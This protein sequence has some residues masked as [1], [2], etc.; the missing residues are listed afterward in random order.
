MSAPSTPVRMEEM[1]WPQVQ[2]ALENGY[3]TVLLAAASIEQHGPHLPT[4]T[5]TLLGY[6]LAEEVALRLGNALVAPVLRPGCSRHHMGFPGSLTL[7]FE[8]FLQ[9]LRDYCHS[10]AECGFR[11]IVLFASHGGNLDLMTAHLP[12][13]AREL[14]D[15][16]RV[17]LVGTG[18][19]AEEEVAYLESL[20]V[21]RE[22]AGVHAGYAETSM[23]LAVRPDLVHMEKAEAGCDDPAFFAPENLKQSQ[24]NSFIYGI[25]SQ[26]PNGIL[27]DARGADAEVGRELLRRKADRLAAQIRA[28]VGAATSAAE[29]KH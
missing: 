6:A 1:T 21:P 20:G 5:D 11:H 23:L 22:K 3:H 13:I 26:S 4:A 24:F 9:V 25:R 10:L 16:C 27:G 12:E 29:G 15:R 17:Y 19:G 8:T 14:V 7:R 2:A 18:P 28:L